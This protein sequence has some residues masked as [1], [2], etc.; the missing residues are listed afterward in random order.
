MSVRLLGLQTES[1]LGRLYGHIPCS[2]TWAL[3]RQVM[4]RFDAPVS[5]LVLVTPTQ[6]SVL[7]DYA[8]RGQLGVS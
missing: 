3:G 5:H 8:K 1:G 2:R 4:R 7:M 6:N